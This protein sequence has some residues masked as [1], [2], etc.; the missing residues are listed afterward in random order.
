MI[1]LKSG[2]T[3]FTGIPTIAPPCEHNTAVKQEVTGI[4]PLMK[5]PATSMTPF[6]PKVEVNSDITYADADKL[7]VI[8]EAVKAVD[9][10]IYVGWDYRD[11]RD[12]DKEPIV[13][14][15]LQGESHLQDYAWSGSAGNVS[16]EERRIISEIT[17]V[18]HGRYPEVDIEDEDVW[19]AFNRGDFEITSD[20]SDILAGMRGIELRG[21]FVFNAGDNSDVAGSMTADSTPVQW[22]TQVYGADPRAV[23]DGLNILWND[24]DDEPKAMELLRRNTPRDLLNGMKA[25]IDA[26]NEHN[27]HHY[28]SDIA[29]PVFVTVEQLVGASLENISI[30]LETSSDNWGV[31]DGVSGA[32]GDIDQNI[33]KLDWTGELLLDEVKQGSRRYTMDEIAGLTDLAFTRIREVR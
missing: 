20:T 29:I 31:Y 6:E 33:R 4:N 11:S 15:A 25:M 24:D 22:L 32:Y 30:V 3:G 8:L 16:D 17:S 9:T 5:P 23:A 26:F 21:T 19:E 28:Y 12:M 1:K 18:C 10:D 13:E 7:A 2:A 27:L 14:A